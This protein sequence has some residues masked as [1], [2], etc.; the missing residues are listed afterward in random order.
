MTPFSPHRHTMHTVNQLLCTCQ[1]SWNLV[2]FLD[3]RTC[4]LHSPR[5][6]MWVATLSRAVLHPFIFLPRSSII[7]SFLKPRLFSVPTIVL[8][9]PLCHSL[10]GTWA[11]ACALPCPCWAQ[12]LCSLGP[13]HLESHA[14]RLQVTTSQHLRPSEFQ[15][16]G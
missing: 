5:G 2:Y 10:V 3:K 4:S 12:P 11:P 14:C 13:H 16:L 6:P 8:S 7:A 9:W 1:V 15:F